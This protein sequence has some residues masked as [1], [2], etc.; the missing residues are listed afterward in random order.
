M[1]IRKVEPDEKQ[2]FNRTIKHPLQSWQWG[3]FKQSTGMKPIRIAEFESGKLIQGYQILLR[4]VPQ[5]NYYVGHSL[6]TPLPTKKL[7]SALRDLAREE[8]II[9][10]KLEPDYI[11]R[12]WPNRKGKIK[13]DQV[14]ENS[15]DLEKFDLTPARRDLFASHSFVIDLTDNADDLMM[16]MHRKTRYNVRL[17]KKKGVE[18]VEESSKNGLKIFNDLLQ[19]TLERQDFY[20]HSPEY[21]RKL[22][23]HLSPDNIAR[24]LLA[25]Y[26]GETLAAWLIFKW[27]DRIFYP[28]GASSSKHRDVMAS[29]L[30]CWETILRGKRWGCKEFDMWGSPGPDVDKDD[31]WYGFYRFKRGYGGDLVEFVGS[32]DLVNNSMLYEGVQFANKVRWAFLNLKQ[33]LPF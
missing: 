30:I 20:L 29:N 4:K 7:I 28:Y 26:Q 32:W 15:V 25:K 17:A 8:N 14:K 24:I 31:P 10:I 23:Q 3:E 11:V 13:T 21:F 27:K 1:I 2:A 16:N 12:R 18:I 6:K 5:T 19:V 33:K 22:W 9:H